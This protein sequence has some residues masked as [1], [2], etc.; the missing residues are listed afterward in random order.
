MGIRSASIHLHD[1]LLFV[2]FNRKLAVVVGLHHLDL[3]RLSHAGIA[4]SV[5][6]VN[7]GHGNRLG[8]ILEHGVNQTRK[9]LADF[10]HEEWQEAVV[11]VS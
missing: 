2:L 1:V 9:N 7:L 6:D 3:R 4:E 5:K 8:D 10:A 11:A